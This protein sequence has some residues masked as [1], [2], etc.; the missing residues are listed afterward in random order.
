MLELVRPTI[1]VKYFDLSQ[2]Y[3]IVEFFFIMDFHNLD[4]ST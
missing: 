1:I 3:N 2:S 4:K